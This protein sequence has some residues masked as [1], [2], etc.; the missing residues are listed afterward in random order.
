MK[1]HRTDAEHV[2]K[3][4]VKVGKW[5]SEKTKEF[6]RHTVALSHG[7]AVYFQGNGKN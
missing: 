5:E 1:L 3:L 4:S 6:H 2:E 7:H